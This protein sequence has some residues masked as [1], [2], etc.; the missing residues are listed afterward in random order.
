MKA[1]S[2]LSTL[3]DDVL[4]T[5]LNHR[6]AKQNVILSNL[7]NAHTPGYRAY[8]YEFEKQLQDAIGNSGQLALHVNDARHFRSMGTTA[9]GQFKGDLFVKPT[10]SIGN[11]GNTVDV[12]QEMAEMAENQ[13]LYKANIELIN[14]RLA[15]LKFAINGGR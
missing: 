12:D 8:G 3:S 13:I 15:M 5:T 1:V 10:E 2:Q 4:E 6:L 14:R 9:N 11:D 7:V